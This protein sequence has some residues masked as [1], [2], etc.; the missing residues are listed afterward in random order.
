MIPIHPALVLGPSFGTAANLSLTTDHFLIKKRL[1]NQRRRYL[2]HNAPML[3]PLV[4]GLIENLVCLARSQ[5]FIPKMNRQ[6]GQLAQL[7]GKDSRLG[8]LRALLSGKVQRIAHH[9][10]RHAEPP[11]QPRQRPKIFSAIAPPLKRKHRLR[12]QTQLVRHRHA[13]A[14]IADIE[15]KIARNWRSFQLRPPGYQLNRVG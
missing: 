12:R 9:N 14:A 7:S 13:N 5:P 15:T 4:P 8:C 10:A 2:I 11:R 3:L 6:A 1:Q